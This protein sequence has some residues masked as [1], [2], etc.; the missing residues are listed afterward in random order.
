MT[1]AWPTALLALGLV[2]L[3]VLCYL[4]SQRRRQR[5]AVRFTNLSLLREVVGKGPSLRRHLPPAMFLLGL[6][7]LLVSLARPSMVMAVPRDEASVMLVIDVSGSMDAK[8]LQPSRLGAAR[9]A[10]KQLVN[11]LPSNAQ[12]GLVEFSDHATVVSPLS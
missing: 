10:A 3:L 12:V 2:P 9:D 6:T 5:Y 7:A 4:W 1:F 11:S 8:D